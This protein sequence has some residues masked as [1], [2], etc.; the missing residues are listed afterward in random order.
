[1]SENNL[2]EKQELLAKI[3]EL[4]QLITKVYIHNTRFN[5]V[6]GQIQA[7]NVDL[8]HYVKQYFDYLLVGSVTAFAMTTPPKGWLVCD[9]REVK[10]EDYSRLFS[11]IGTNFGEGDSITT[12]NLPNLNGVFVRGYDSQGEHDPKRKFGK[13]QGDQIQS[14][15]HKDIGHSHTGETSEDG[16]HDHSEK[17]KI[18]LPKLVDFIGS[19][20]KLPNE[21]EKEE[22]LA[23]A[24]MGIEEATAPHCKGGY[25]S[26]DGEHRHSG[27]VDSSG[28]H[29]HSGKTYKDGSH[30]HIDYCKERY[31]TD[32]WF[33]DTEP[34]S[35]V[36]SSG[37]DSLQIGSDESSHQHSLNINSAGN[38]SHSISVDGLHSH[39]VFI[40]PDGIHSH[41]VSTQ[42]AHASLGN[43][44][45][46]SGNA[47]Q[48]GSETR[49]KNVAL[50][51]CI[52]Y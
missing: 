31:V 5:L 29:Y 36:H 47:I 22:N 30:H 34:L 44:V 13:Y 4:E 45:N 2:P 11:R 52:K 27:S 17:N 25:T 41:Q 46:Y 26:M 37:T 51:Y 18:D 3:A 32:G 6:E 21:I 38:H 39:K 23:I 8:R 43:P 15:T 9:G 1:M 40:E 16:E 49:P 24:K 10:R 28:S 33:G 7:T 48:H 35:N 12:F 19:S 50:L 14:H 42:T 20:R